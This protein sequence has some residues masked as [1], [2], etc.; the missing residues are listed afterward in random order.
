MIQARADAGERYTWAP[1][2]RGFILGFSSMTS[3]RSTLTRSLLVFGILASVG[4]CQFGLPPGLVSSTFHN[5]VSTPTALTVDP[6][7]VVYLSTQ[8]G[9]IKT[10]RDLDGDHF[11][12]T[13]TVFWSGAGIS[14]PTLGLQW[15]QGSL[16]VS[17]FETISRI[18]DFDNDLIG[19]VRV[20]L[21]TNL[22]YG[23]HFN[24]NLFTDGTAL[25]FGLGSVTD[26]SVDPDPRSATLMRMNSDGS[27]PTIF[28]T[29]LRN[30][31]DGAVHPVSGDIFVGDNGPNLV[32]GNPDP[33]DE[34]NRVVFGGDYGH[35]NNWGTPP[36]GSGA[37]APEY[38]LPT[39][40]SPT[41]MAINPGTAL[42]G[43][44][45]EL[46]MTTFGGYTTT[47]VRFPLSYHPVSG[48]L[49]MNF[50]AVCVHGVSV[51][52][53]QPMG[54]AIDLI[55]GATGELFVADYTN[56]SVYK[57]RQTHAARI[58]VDGPGTIGTT[59]PIELSAPGFGGQLAFAAAS[60][61][62]LGSPLVVGP[63]L[64][65]DLDLNSPIF[66]LSLTPG[67]G[68]FNFP[69]PG[70]LD[71][72]GS[73]QASITIPYEPLLVGYDLRLQWLVID[74]VQAIILSISP[75]QGFYITG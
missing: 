38:L 20:D 53:S 66:Q 57:I 26:H 40:A 60:S 34:I 52:C 42:S 23:W 68:I 64:Q 56:R 50:E 19:D 2:T 22:P 13:V 1:S 65:I 41:G 43:H 29:G 58:V 24:N 69:Q 5:D 27:N 49:T 18:T 54:A 46:W 11:A 62:A 6:Q 16:F 72:S 21:L 47:I 14:A 7:G 17:H 73:I 48:A 67:N 75:P 63:G 59:C 51:A 36:S 45:N 35:P 8:D 71:A 39:H 28:A 32:P 37:I 30:V 15:L 74:A 10:L 33:P 61:Y 70:V 25:Y 31:Y 55:F 9:V 12:E 4:F 44:R 3:C